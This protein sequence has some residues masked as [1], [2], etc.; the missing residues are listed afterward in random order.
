M[1]NIIDLTG[2]KILVTGA[3]SGIGR[4]TSILLSQIGANV[5][6]V[7][8]NDKELTNTM[9][10][11]NDGNHKSFTCD[12]MELENV[13]ELVLNAVDY[14]GNKLDGLVHCAG[15]S[16]DLPLKNLEY[17]KMDQ[18]MKTNFYSFIELVKNFSRKNISGGGSIVGVSSRA[19]IGGAKCQTIYSAS[20]AA[21]D[22]SVRTL[23]IELVQKKIRINSVRPGFIKTALVNNYMETC[24]VGSA[25]E[26][27]LLGIGEP[28][29]VANLIAFLLSDATRFITGR[30]FEVD[31][32]RF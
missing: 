32:G 8:R 24:G 17:N 5:V 15:I 12:L 19:A 23:A 31:G 3:S 16:I 10:A 30:S 13:K 2:R 26:R 14:D 27:Q 9:A 11:M 22:A 7:G 21:L 1:K 6:I 20:K 29:D 28:I 4:E 25:G 18:L